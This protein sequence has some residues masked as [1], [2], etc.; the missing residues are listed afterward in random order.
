MRDK[1]YAESMV[2]NSATRWSQS[3]NGGL[4]EGGVDLWV[5]GQFEFNATVVS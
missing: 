5:V 2:P 3:A 4:S 1:Q